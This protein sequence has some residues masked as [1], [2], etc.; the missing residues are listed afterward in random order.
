MH[1]NFRAFLDLDRLTHSGFKGLI[2]AAT[3]LIVLGSDATIFGV[4]RGD[5]RGHGLL[6]SDR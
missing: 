3:P 6:E 5:I 4:Y 2:V 1:G